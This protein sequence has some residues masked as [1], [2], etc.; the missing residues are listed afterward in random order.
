MDLTRI[1][2]E[3]QEMA[4]AATEM[5]RYLHAHPELSWGEVETSRFI[6]RRLKEIGFQ[7]IRVGVDG[8]AVG[9]VADLAGK[10]AGPCVALRADIDALNLVEE[11]DVPYKSKCGAMHACGH[12]AH[13]TML[14]GA[15]RILYSM[16]D[17]LPGSV[18]FIFQPAEEHGMHSGAATMIEEGVLDGVGALAGMHLWSHVPSGRVQ[19]RSGPVMASAD[20]WNVK[21]RGRG[22]HGA[23]P[24]KTIDPVVAAANFILALQTIVSRE[25]NPLETAVLSVGKLVSGEVINIIPEVAEMIGN[26]RTFSVEVRDQMEESFRRIADGIA[27][28]YRCN[29]ETQY[30]RIY[31]YPVVND[32]V[33]SELLRDTA[34]ALVGK[35]DVEES[36]MLMTSEDFSFYQ[37]KVRSVFFF[38]GSG[39]E[40]KGTTA[41][42]HSSRFDVDD[43]VLPRG[44]ALMSS[45]ACAALSGMSEGT[46]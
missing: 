1:R 8:K 32:R 19:W 6:A 2:N 15:A 7:D 41:A 10:E 44:I 45:F 11:N 46:L 24:H 37:T 38:L 9:V 12:D 23:M 14:L 25:V 30:T 29:L 27:A 26:I 4:G 3:A 17:E 40:A 39:D 35:A 36:P 22:G 34:I 18:R 33:L 31:P 43:D 20:G 42:H 13:I 28:T 16:K 21:F 5:R